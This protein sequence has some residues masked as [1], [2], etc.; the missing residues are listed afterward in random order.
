MSCTTTTCAPTAWRPPRTTD[1]PADGRRRRRSKARGR[2]AARA[3]KRDCKY[4]LQLRQFQCQERTRREGRKKEGVKS[5]SGEGW[6][7][8]SQMPKCIKC[9]L[10][11]IWHRHCQLSLEFHVHPSSHNERTILS[12][13]VPILVDP[14]V[15]NSSMD[16]QNSVQMLLFTRRGRA[17]AFPLLQGNKIDY[18]G[19]IYAVQY[20]SVNVIVHRR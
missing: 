8:T 7:R 10:V 17:P 9:M 13:F 4:L 12:Q 15:R 16:S 2:G 14:S 11:W 20:A 5:T 6:N 3:G 1:R 19:I 18:R